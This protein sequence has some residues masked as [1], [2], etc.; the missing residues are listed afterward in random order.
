[1]EFY[2]ISSLY[3][4]SPY[5][6]SIPNGMEFYTTTNLQS[7][8]PIS[9]QFPTGWNSTILEGGR[10][11]EKDGFN[12]QR[13]GILLVSGYLAHYTGP[14]QFP[15]GWNSTLK[16]KKSR[17]LTLMVSIP[18]GMEFYQ[19]RKDLFSRLSNCFNSQRDGIL[20]EPIVK[21]FF[22]RA[23]Q[24]PTG[25]NSTIPTS[26]SLFP[27]SLVSIPNGMEFYTFLSAPGLT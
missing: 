1:M 14:F 24:F 10:I 9:F 4:F 26:P 7:W 21:L 3:I 16:A 8:S 23:F 13:D 6:V 19:K 18:N 27:L 12:S 20:L 25:W 2:D 17:L 22:L 11:G 15:T 5:S